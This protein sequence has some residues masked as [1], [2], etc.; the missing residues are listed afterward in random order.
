MIK[1]KYYCIDPYKNINIA[2]QPDKGSGINT[3]VPIGIDILCDACNKKILSL[4]YNHDED[5]LKMYDYSSYT[6][7]YG[8]DEAKNFENEENLK[9][10]ILSRGLFL[11]CSKC[12]N[13][14]KYIND[15]VGMKNVLEFTNTEIEEYIPDFYNEI[16]KYKRIDT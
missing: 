2:N 11:C 6:Y 16:L 8:T 13:D 15:T 3:R 1:M 7:F 12:Y 9:K 10:L 4:L 14:Q 5:K